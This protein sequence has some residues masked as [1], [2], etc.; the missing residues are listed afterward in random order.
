MNRKDWLSLVAVHSDS[1][2]LSAAFYL[3]AR[4]NRNEDYQSY[5]STPSILTSKF[6]KDLL[7]SRQLVIIQAHR[8]CS[9]LSLGFPTHQPYA[10]R[11]YSITLLPMF[12]SDAKGNI[13]SNWPALA[14]LFLVGLLVVFRSINLVGG[15][16][17]W[18]AKVLAYRLKGVLAKVIS[19]A[20]NA[21]VEGR[22]IMDA[23]LIANEGIDSIL[24]INLDKSEMI[25]VGRVENVEEL[26]SE[27]GCKVG[28]LPFYLGMPLGAPFISVVAW[29]RIEERFHKRLT[30]WK[31]RYISKRGRITLIQTGKKGEVRALDSLDLSMIGRWM[32]WKG[33]SLF[34]KGNPLGAWKARNII[35][36]EDSVLSIQ[37]CKRVSVSFMVLKGV[38]RRNAELQRLALLKVQPVEDGAVRLWPGAKLQKGMLLYFFFSFVMIHF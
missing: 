27:L 12:P 32:R 26:A 14:S 6:W 30:M 11:C 2:L 20:Q 29:D 8:E 34:G 9:T 37:S 10:C 13:P 1:W 35:A 33:V 23:V 22:Q 18:L 24:K 21:L 15:L 36:F 16:Y 4:L 7:D 3:G 5:T 28:R 25:H 19:K 17:K 31:R 38:P